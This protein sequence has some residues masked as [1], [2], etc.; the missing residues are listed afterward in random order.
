MAVDINRLPQDAA[1]LDPV[2]LTQ[3]LRAGGVLSSGSFVTA[4]DAQQLGAGAGLIGM[5]GR[6]HLTYGGAPTDAPTRM[7]CLF[8]LSIQTGESGCSFTRSSGLPN[9]C[10]GV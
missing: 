3:A 9:R 5:V 7:I 2:W 10:M 6:V 1:S 4:C 8:S